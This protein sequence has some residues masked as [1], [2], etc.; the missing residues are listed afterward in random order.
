MLAFCDLKK[1]RFCVEIAVCPDVLS[2][3]CCLK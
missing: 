2:L 3:E 1:N